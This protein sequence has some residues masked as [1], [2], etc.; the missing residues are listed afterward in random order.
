MFV[1][2][3]DYIISEALAARDIDPNLM[4]CG[5]DENSGRRSVLQPAL[6]LHLQVR[7]ASGLLLLRCWRLE[8]IQMRAILLVTWLIVGQPPNS[9]QVV[10]NSMEACTAARNAVL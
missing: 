9:Y 4:G 10:F 5:R 7:R 8:A 3:V 1:R 2:P 6:S